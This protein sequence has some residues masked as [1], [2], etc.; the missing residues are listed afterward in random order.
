M[1][2][3]ALSVHDGAEAELRS[4]RRRSGRGWNIDPALAPPNSGLN[5]CLL[6]AGA[7]DV[8]LPT[9]SLYRGSS[10]G[11]SYY[12]LHASRFR[13]FGGTTNRWGGWCRPLDAEDYE[14]HDWVPRSGWPIVHE[15]VAAYDADAAALLQLPSENFEVARWADPRA[16]PIPLESSEF[17]NA[18]YQY[19]PRT[20]FGEV[21]GP[22][23]LNAPNVRTILNANVTQLRLEPG[24]RR[25]KEAI[26]RT[27]N[28]R[29][30]TVRAKTFVLATGG[31]E[32]A[33]LLLASNE[34]QPEG[35][36]NEYDNVGRYFQEHLHVAAGHLLPTRPFDRAFYER[37]KTEDGEA[38]G[39]IV[40]TA[41]AQ[42]R[43]RRLACSIA[44]EPPHY[45]MGTPFLAWPPEITFRAAAAYNHLKGSGHAE[46]AERARQ[47]A[48]H[49]WYRAR[50]LRTVLAERDAHTRARA[51]NEDGR[52]GRGGR[53]PEHE[54]Q[55][56]Y[57]RAEQAPNPDSRV[58]LSTKRDALG[59]PQ[60]HLEWRLTDLDTNSVT[61]WLSSLDADLQ[62]NGIGQVIAP[63][64][65]W[66]R[67]IV[68]GPH[69]MGTTRMGEDP[70]TSVVDRN[71]RVHSVENLYVAGSSVFTTGGHANPT[72][73][74]VALALRLADHLKQTLTGTSAV[75]T[76]LDTRVG[77]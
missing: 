23:I 45:A 41:D 37:A 69:H 49:N 48:E 52:G 36:G 72:F 55:S 70:R 53:G 2:I 30:F 29:Q 38:R 10:S 28:G 33:R 8:D 14:E 50:R 1:L 60:A 12:P 34:D 74:I 67:R 76:G 17:E 15:D 7:F 71:C 65:S 4:V 20:N 58:T 75:P 18:I 77:G 35:L 62:A 43:H 66:R 56:L 54:L 13:M 27:L 6:E 47:I 39:V 19:S 63:R 57:I 16:E 68:G 44:I 51:R 59:M 22:E 9:Q 24:T 32:N 42:R 40:P 26:V 61:G 3:D 73:T 31:I 21:Y 5:I 46:L 64:T 25:V 11:Q